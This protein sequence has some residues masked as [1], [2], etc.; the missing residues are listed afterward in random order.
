METAPFDTEVTPGRLRRPLK[1]VRIQRTR[2]LGRTLAPSELW[3]YR[4]VAVQIAARD[5]KVRYRQTALGVAWAVLQPFGTMVVFAIFFGHLAHVPSEGGSYALSALAALVPW[6]YFANGLSV[7]SDSLVANVALV[8]KIYFPRIFIPAG[9][10]AAGILDLV[11]GSAMLLVIVGALGRSPSVGVAVLPVLAV[12]TAATALGVSSAASALAVRYRDVRFLV[13][14][15]VQLLLFVSPV[16]YPNTLL[17]EPWR[18]VSAINPM[19]G[20][21]EG[22]RWAALGTTAPWLLIAISAASALLLLFG[23]LVY[24]EHAERS[25]ADIL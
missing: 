7:G 5:V 17:P 1:T 9:V 21:I 4:D 12:I 10:V 24:F 18:T 19:V 2:G 15:A 16:A 25:F 13:P 11:V 20:V 6:T 14:F 22:Y 3:R 8:S 23:G